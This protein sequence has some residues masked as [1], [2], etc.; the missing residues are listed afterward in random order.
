MKTCKIL[1]ASAF[2]ISHP[3]SYILFYSVLYN[4]SLYRGIFPDHLK[5]AIVEPLYKEADK[6]CMTNYRPILLLTL[7][8]EVLKNSMH[9]SLSQQLHTNNI[10][11]T[12]KYGF[13][14]GISTE[15]TAFW[16]TNSV[17][18]SISYKIHVGGIFIELVKV[19]LV[20]IMKFC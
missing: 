7:F 5:I 12:E 17:F 18:K 16:L 4:H 20:W 19:L 13:R 11:V 2:L 10:L 14:K 15:N 1:K 3:L 9:R 6:A 8:P